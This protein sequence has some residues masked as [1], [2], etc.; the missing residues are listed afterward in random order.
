MCDKELLVGYLYDEIEPDGAAGVRGASGL[1][2]GLPRR[3]SR[4][5]A[6]TRG[7]SRRWTPPEPGFELARSCAERRRPAGAATWTVSPAWGLAAAAVL[8]LRWPRRSRMSRCGYGADGLTCAPA[9]RAGPCRPRPRVRRA[10]GSSCR[11][12]SDATLQPRARGDS[13]G[14]SA[15]SRQPPRPSPAKPAGVRGAAT[16]G[17]GRLRPCAQLVADSEAGSSRSSRCG[18]R[19]SCATSRRR[20]AG[21]SRPHP[22]RPRAGAGA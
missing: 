10:G 9:G 11:G 7:S 22:A 17:P 16:G 5:C 4:S 13:A 14:A 20:R 6:A 2:R 19:R 8:V 18:S 3:R 1:V 12:R 21:R 15:R